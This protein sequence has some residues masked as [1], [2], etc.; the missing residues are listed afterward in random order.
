MEI[1]KKENIW[2][3]PMETVLFILYFNITHFGMLKLDTF[4]STNKMYKELSYNRKLYVVKNIFKFIHLSFLSFIAL[5]VGL[6]TIVYNIWD[7]DKIRLLGLVYG[8]PDTY[9]LFFI[10]KLPNATKIH[11]SCV[12]ILYISF[13]TNY[14]NLMQITYWRGIVVYCIFSVLSGSVNGYLGLRF[15]LEDNYYK[16]QLKKFA[17]YN[18]LLCIIIIWTYQYYIFYSYLYNPRTIGFYLYFIVCHLILY[19]DII[20]IKFLRK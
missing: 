11:H 15:I 17:Y 1:I 19:D 20:L 2:F 6:S 12:T 7:T 9:A 13:L 8:V 18:Y 5:Y 3:I 10:K 14:L 4:I 16:K